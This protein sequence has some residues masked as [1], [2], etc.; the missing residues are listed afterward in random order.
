M[1]N[2]GFRGKRANDGTGI[3]NPQENFVQNKYPVP[4]INSWT[5]SGSD[6]DALNPAGGQTVLVN[7]GGFFAGCAVSVNGVT[8]T[9]VTV[10]SA[11]QISFTSPAL[12]GGSYTLIVYN[13]AGGGAILVPGLVY[14]SVPTYTTAQG[15]I[16]SGYETTD[17]DTSV[18]ATSDSSITYTITSGALPSGASMTS[19][20]VITGTYPT[21]A[22]GTS[23][24]F[25]FD[26]TATDAEDQD[27]TRSFTLT[28]NIDVVTWVTPSSGATITLDGT[29]YSQAL[30]ATD[31]A[32]YSVS[33][34]ANALPTGLTLSSGTIS[35]TPTVD[36]TTT[37]L[38]TATAATTNRSATNTITWVVSLSD[39]FWKNVTLLL[40][41]STP[42]T[43]F[44]NDASLNNSQLTIYGDAKPNN[45]NPY[46]QG[47]YS[48]Y[49]D[50]TGDSVTTAGNSTLDLGTGDFTIE[51]F[52]ISNGYEGSQ[53]GRG[54]FA[55]YPSGNYVNRMIVRHSSV[56]QILAIY[57]YNGSSTYFG[58]SGT[59]G[60]I[61]LVRGAWYHVAFVR[62]SGV[63]RLYINGVQDIVVSDQTSISLAN[64]NCFDIGRVQEGS[65]PEWNGII[66][67]F[68]VIK[69]TCLYPSGTTFTPP[70][71]LL[72]N[73]SGTSL[74]T[75][76]SN[77]LID[78][79]VNNI[80]IT[81]NGDTK[82]ISTHPFTTPTT[83]AY[84]T[85]YSTYF[86]GAGDYLTLP[87][88]QSAFT[89][90]TGD[91]TVEMWVYTSS[92]A[93]GQT[94][95]D[96]MNGGDSGGSGRF[97]MQLST[98]GTVQ[99]FTGAGSI[100]TSGG[101][102]AINTWYHIAYSR[103]SNS[104]KLYVNGN[105]VN[106]TYTDN[107]N[108]VVGTS[109]RPIIGINAYDSSTNPMLG[110]ISNLRVV[111]GVGVY[112]GAFTPP[113][114][115]LT[116]TQDAGT[117]IAAIA[118]TSTSLLTCQDATLKDNSTNNFTISS[119]NQPKPIAVSPFTMTTS[120]TTVTSLGSAY[121][122]GT[123]DYLS[124][125]Y[126]PAFSL[127]TT[128]T[129]Q[130]WVYPTVLNATNSVFNIL[131]AVTT[132][133]GGCL[134]TV[135]SSGSVWFETRPGNGGTNVQLIGGTVALNTWSHI[136]VSVNAT[137][138]KLFVNGI[139][140][141]TGTIAA[142]DGTQ[143]YVGIGS[144]TN[145][146]TANPWTGYIND[147]NVNRGTALY[148][149]NFL[150]PQAPLT[151]VAN[152]QLLTCQTNG[153]ATNNGFVD[154][155]SFNNIITRNGNTTQGTFSPF[156]QTGWSTYFNGSV[157]NQYFL[158]PTATAT[159][160]GGFNG[161][162]TTIEFWIYQTQTSTAS[163]ENEIFG[164]FAAAAANGRFIIT[165]GSA[166][167]TNSPSKV[168]FM[169]TT[170]TGTIDTIIAT[171]TIAVSTWAHVAIVVDATGTAGAHTVTIYTNG[172]GETFTGKNF[173]S[174]TL[175]YDRLRIAGNTE[176]YLYGYL[177][178]FRVTRATTNTVGY[179]GASI[180]VP[181]AP[182]QSLASTRLLL[183]QS[184][185]FV[186]NSATEPTFTIS[187]TPSI[188]A[189]SP[190]GGVTSVPTSYSSKFTSSSQ[191]Y[192][193]S[194]QSSVFAFGTSAYTIEAWV[195]FKTLATYRTIFGVVGA[196]STYYGPRLTLMSTGALRLW[197]ADSTYLTTAEGIISA[198]TLYH[199]AWVRES[200][201][202]L[203]LYVNGTSVYTVTTGAIVTTDL[204]GTPYVDIGY[205]Y[206]YGHYMD[207]YISNF[208]IVK[209]V[210]VYT[211]NF[212][213]P[214]S[215][216]SAT[217]SAGTNIS[218]ITTG[219]TSLL[220]CQSNTIIDNSTNRFAI[221]VTNNPTVH[222]Y[223][224]FG[225]TTTTSVSYTPSVNGGSMYFDGT[226]DYLQTATG[227][228][229]TDITQ[230]NYTIECWV[231]NM[232]PGAER[233][234]FSQ[235]GSG[236]GW[237]MRIN[238]DNTVSTFF[239]GGTT[240]TTTGTVPGNAWTHIAATRLGT[241]IRVFINGVQSATGTQSN[242]TSAYASYGLWL[243]YST[244]GGGL[245]LG[246]I[247]DARVIK[248]QSLYNTNFYPGAAP[249]TLTNDTAYLL[250]GTSGGIIDY[251]GTNNLET[252]GNTQ[253]AS[254]DP[255]AGSYYSNYFNNAT[256]DYLTVSYNSGFDV[257][258]GSFSI[259][260][261]VNIT[262]LFNTNIDSKRVGTIAEFGPASTNV[263]W[264]LVINQTDSQ[265][266]FSVQGVNNKMLCSYSFTLGQWYH[267]AVIRNSSSNAIYVNGIAQTLT[268]DNYTGSSATSGNVTI[269]TAR[270]FTGYN[271]DFLGYISNLR[272]VKGTA[273][274]TSNFTPSTTPLTD[275]SGTSLLTCQSNSF[276]DNSTNAFTITKSGGP[277]VKSQNPF[278]NNTGKSLYFNG[279]SNALLFPGSSV[280]SG[281]GSAFT[282]EIWIY[283]TALSFVVLRCN[284]NASSLGI[285]TNASGQI[286]LS[287][288]F[289]ADFLTATG[290]AVTINAWNYVA[291]TRTTANLYTVYLNGNSVGSV[292]YTSS[293]GEQPMYIG[294][295]TYNSAYYNYYIKDLRITKGVARTI[296]VPTSPFKTN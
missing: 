32:G 293:L 159:A 259:E 225:T 133:F 160:L 78:N 103:I 218:A 36:S 60:T 158:L 76:Q 31:A 250:N 75:C 109:S 2:T 215:S 291:I 184:N 84:N 156:S 242:G 213:V 223:N 170:S 149:S 222:S 181:T 162:F 228:I 188:Q 175:T 226:G 229:H 112:T 144:F 231:Y 289:V 82:V 115:P 169:W 33:Y 207:G 92:L 72:T 199:I 113:A 94:F 281:A 161:N 237:E 210:A 97:A 55:L 128:Y 287:N 171:N 7:G 178:N 283:P 270:R 45:F 296:A 20:G 23:E 262:G 28:T 208:R 295:N 202:L 105:Q 232:G 200:T 253:L 209:G 197:N 38:L 51:C 255:Y 8:I 246:Y 50:G 57:G 6:D 179:S 211:G 41:G 99:L 98:G 24:T 235:R 294:Y 87:S 268:T 132:N 89:M 104:G 288:T 62:Q 142:L 284:G 80:Q 273:V 29:S 155:S 119:V 173:S 35:G 59:G 114:S 148:T 143:T 74:L 139:Q 63:F 166:A 256:P 4:T 1:F 10:I 212:T 195:N 34:A 124:V 13:S 88:N 146:H 150:P 44:I 201:S 191:Q 177:S 3:I 135:S 205:F 227:L 276:K 116:A 42:T 278:Q 214:T 204:T 71:T 56:G 236:S 110:S 152:T 127:G 17:I 134:I 100:F 125:P 95:Y 147:L 14:S 164:T 176:S 220:T 243:G 239:T 182:L 165:I 265:I 154:Q 145:G 257:A 275:V 198:N 96:T 272:I 52:T 185:R 194:P 5:I 267:I 153:G 219:Q 117:N 46:E 252:V 54:L 260:C 37:T 249:A 269:G 157:A 137:A 30:S 163:T 282:F 217:Q 120:N 21:L 12:A 234:I 130:A 64:S 43:T 102:L 290:G 85:Q 251:H 65:T 233:Y 70:T 172:V 68:R 180:S 258:S 15:S 73:I 81:K 118:G 286:I 25:Y 244:S 91:F 129:I 279:T 11:N 141:A 53:Y 151:P 48:N 285:S 140:V 122:D 39:V 77:R 131:N 245:M 247:S 22:V 90:G 106:T 241:T 183:C 40:N 83:A 111:K 280:P 27:V 263:G 193:T 126:S 61:N 271:H 190:F 248:G 58:S 264:E 108:Y 254:E 186:D 107:N 174:Q 123:G 187:G 101:T 93:V 167:A 16:G 136:A 292:T 277:K 47:Y 79:S 9:P 192:L 138:A 121:F 196:A 238:S 19:G 18:V 261:W 221:T 69:G 240:F 49:F 224:P 26:I 274:Y 203:K 266:Q 216:L 168:R 230:T 189:Y 66:S 86:D 67:N 206:G